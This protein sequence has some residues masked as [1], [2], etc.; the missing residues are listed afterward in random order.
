MIYAINRQTKEHEVAFS[1]EAHAAENAFGG[2]PEA[3]NG[4]EFV[5]ADDDGWIPW[6]GDRECPLPVGHPYQVTFAYKKRLTIMFLSS[7][8]QIHLTGI[9][10][11][12]VV[13]LLH[14]V[15]S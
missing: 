11:I 2:I 10:V 4:Y 12:L 7:V 6:N 15:L 5:E 1:N 13:I 3:P 14:T 9:T 8:N